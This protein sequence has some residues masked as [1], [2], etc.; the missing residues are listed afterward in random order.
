MYDGGIG[1]D[2]SIAGNTAVD[3]SFGKLADD[4]NTGELEVIG[5]WS[6]DEKVRSSTWRELETVRRILFS[7]SEILANR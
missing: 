4:N 5:I 6:N 2:Y 1:N 7:K 3:A